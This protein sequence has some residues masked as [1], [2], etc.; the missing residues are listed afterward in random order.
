VAAL[1]H[2]FDEFIIGGLLVDGATR[3]AQGVGN[4]FRRFAQNGSLSSYAYLMGLGA[5]LV[6]YFTVFA[7]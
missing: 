2:F 1:V 5:V 4:I 3:S 7:K 6:I